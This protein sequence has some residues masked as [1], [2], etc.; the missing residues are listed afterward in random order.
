MNILQISANDNRI[1]GASGVALKIKEGL[2]KQNIP[3]SFFCGIKNSNSSNVYEI[4]KKKTD[5][6][7]SF[8]FADD[9]SFFKT[10]FILET[11]QFKEADIIQCHNLHGWYFNLETLKKMAEKKPVVWTFHDIW[12]VTPHCSHSEEKIENGF[13]KCPSLDVYP[14]L[15]WHNEKKL[16][17]KKRKIYNESNFNIVTPS[18]WL[19]EKLKGTILENKPTTLIYNGIDTDIFSPKN[20]DESREKLGLPKDKKIVLFISNNG[21]KTDF[22]G[23]GHFLKISKELLNDKSALFLCLGGNENESIDNIDFVKK[24]ADE[25]TLAL[26]F[27][28]ADILLYPSLADNFPLVI[29]EAMSCGLPIV[30]FGT[31]GIK[32]VV[33][34]KVNGYVAKYNVTEDLLVGVNYILNLNTKDLEKISTESRDK[35]I[36][37]FSLNK[38]VNEYIELYKSLLKK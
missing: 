18:L 29:L 4:P 37:H 20:K 16:I 12:P 8:L 9:M 2:D 36:N 34:N 22:K 1:G 21:V 17:S 11:K 31:G 30:T 33:T 26:Y 25:N 15:L 5:R 35:I 28:A 3:N 14:T 38:M 23:G 19:K 6:I 7:K 27:S 24:T 10:D 13:Y 32:E